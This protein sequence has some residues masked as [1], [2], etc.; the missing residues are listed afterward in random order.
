MNV[1]RMAKAN[2][3]GMAPPAAPT[4]REER[5][6]TR[7][8]RRR[9]RDG[10]RVVTLLPL[11]AAILALLLLVVV[12]V[13]A[14]SLDLGFLDAL[15]A[16]IL[17]ALGSPTTDDDRG[18]LKIVVLVAVI[19]GGALLGIFFSYLASVATV[20]R[21]ERRT[22]RAALRLN[23]HAVV[24]GLGTIG[25]RIVRILGDLGFQTA[26]I[27]RAPD[28]R[29]ADA[30]D[31]ERTLV[32]VG[33]AR[34]REHLERARVADAVALFA[35]TDGDLANIETCLQARRLR[36]GITTVARMFDERLA[37]RMTGAL[38][39]DR[40][41]SASRVAAGAFVGAATDER[42]VRR[43][44]VGSEPYVALRREADR[45]IPREEVDR[46]R[47]DGARVL[48][49]RRGGEVHPPSSLTDGLVEGDS[50]IMAGPRD[51]VFGHLGLAPT[52]EA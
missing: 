49:F 36:P 15:Y 48:A 22:A 3:P 14:I 34:L 12:L 7:A 41:L 52:D 10:P 1:L 4:R 38:G 43:F 46:W 23:G 19:A 42:A 8:E 47:A 11:F 16:A 13:F 27:D 50:F 26:V 28:P 21:W 6:R 29:F 51:V 9:H 35:C 32:L 37:D 24:T 40:A 31:E 18:W 39:I 44:L 33:D 2:A 17:T 25:Y 20:N 5:R 30:L 45:T